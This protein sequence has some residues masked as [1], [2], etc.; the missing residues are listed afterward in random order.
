MQADDP[1][2]PGEDREP[3]PVRERVVQPAE[4]AARVGVD[5]GPQPGDQRHDADR[6]DHQRQAA[7]RPREPVLARR[8]RRAQD[9]HE[10]VD[11]QAAEL[12]Q[13]A[14]GR[15]RP[16]GR[17]QD[18]GAEQRE[19]AGGDA[20][21]DAEPGERPLDRGHAHRERDGGHR[22]QRRPRAGEEPAGLEGEQRDAEPRDQGRKDGGS[23]S[24]PG[25]RAQILGGGAQPCA[26]AA[27][28]GRPA[29][30][31][32]TAA[33]PNSSTLAMIERARARVEAAQLVVA[34]AAEELGGARRTRA[35]GA[36]RSGP[37]PTTFSLRRLRLR[38]ASSAISIALVATRPR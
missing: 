16:L 35:A 33:I 13:R 9:Q 26:S 4:P 5:V 38:A 29:A 17:E 37:V 3:V 21:P 15:A 24:G 14:T 23:A 6:P 1:A 25:H 20:A 12:D 8:Q 2:D 27:S 7:Q 34:D 19:R 36:A 10:Q 22:R 30:C 32:S 11:E 28:T 18:P 31:A